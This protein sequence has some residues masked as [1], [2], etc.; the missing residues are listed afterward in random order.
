MS[1]AWGYCWCLA[2]RWHTLPSA[3]NGFNPHKLEEVAQQ[4]AKITGIMHAVCVCVCVFVCFGE[5]GRREGVEEL[6]RDGW[7]SRSV[8][9]GSVKEQQLGQGPFSGTPKLDLNKERWHKRKAESNHFA[10]AEEDPELDAL[11]TWGHK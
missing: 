3:T 10:F 5:E 4:E 2:P 7:E 6:W 1:P 9:R 8:Y 11:E